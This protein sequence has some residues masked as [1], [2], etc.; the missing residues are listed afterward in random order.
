MDKKMQ[1]RELHENDQSQWLTLWRAYQVFYHADIPAETT[2]ITFSRLLDPRETMFALV[3]EQAG[4]LIGF[5][6]YLWHRSTWTVGNSCYLQD[7]FVDPEQRHQGV[8]KQLIEAV[9]AKAA[10]HQCARVYWLT[11]E[12]NHAARSLY[13]QVAEQ[14]GFIQYRKNMA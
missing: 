13:D 1:I 5:V 10:E 12:H 7:L 3:I 9:Y 2:Q 14:T 8:G 11:Q 4:I 6:H